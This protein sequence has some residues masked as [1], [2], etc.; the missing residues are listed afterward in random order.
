MQWGNL[1]INKRSIRTTSASRVARHYS[2]VGTTFPKPTLSTWHYRKRHIFHECTCIQYFCWQYFCRQYFY[3][4]YF[5]QQYFYGQCM[6]HIHMSLR[7]VGC[8][9]KNIVRMVVFCHCRNLFGLEPILRLLNLQLQRQ[10][11]SRL[12]RFLKFR[13]IIV[14]LTSALS[15]L[16]RCKIL[17]RWGCNS[18]S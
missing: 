7:Q 13:K 14:I 18:R 10:H 1:G 9:Q 2:S 11:C 8:R 4:Q 12:D 5:Y 3:R 17:Q 15:Y 16:L 6:T